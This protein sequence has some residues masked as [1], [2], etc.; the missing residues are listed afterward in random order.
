MDNNRLRSPPGAQQAI[1]ILMMVKWVPAAPI[2]QFDVR[3]DEIKAVILERLARVEQHIGDA[4]D[5]NKTFYRIETDRQGG[6]RG[7]RAHIGNP[8]YTAVAEAKPAAREPDLTEYRCERDHRPE[9]LLPMIAALQ[10]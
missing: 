6:R 3:V 7:R 9:W 1:D 10:G 5:R 8:F 4:R 2:D